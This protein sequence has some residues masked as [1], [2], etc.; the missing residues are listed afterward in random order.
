MR[1]EHLAFVTLVLLTATQAQANGDSRQAREKS[2]R[3]ACIT[4]DVPKGIDILGD[5]FVET[6]DINYVFNQ[7]RCYQQNHRWEEA[8]DRFT[9][10]RRK[11]RKLSAEEEA[12]L[13]GYIADCKTQIEKTKPSPHDVGATTGV[14]VSPPTPPSTG[15]ERAEASSLRKEAA[16]V[17]TSAGA[18]PGAALRTAGI[19]VSAVGVA[20]IAGGVAMALKTQSLVDT[21]K[22]SGYDSGQDSSR[23]SYETWGWISYGVGAAGLLA[24]ATMYLIGA[25]S[26][27]DAG[28]LTKISFAPILDRDRAM[29]MVQGAVR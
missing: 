17:S 20:A 9:E 10:F 7:A 12:E 2:A 23:R 16:G 11:V 15:P 28:S 25:L 22:K 24:G 8:L 4:G 29:L 27:Q 26:R 1:L 19:V 18:R 3:K 21:M 6:G 13:E 5:L 14:S